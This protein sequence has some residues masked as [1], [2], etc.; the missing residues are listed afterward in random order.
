M[1]IH[2]SCHPLDRRFAIDLSTYLRN[3]GFAS[4]LMQSICNNVETKIAKS[5]VVIVILRPEYINSLVYQY[6]SEK[7][8]NIRLFPI[9]RSPIDI[10]DWNRNIVLSPVVDFTNHNKEQVTS[11]LRKMGDLL[12]SYSVATSVTKLNLQEIYLD[13]LEATL[14]RQYFTVDL[15]ETTNYGCDSMSENPVHTFLSETLFKVFSKNKEG[16]DSAGYPSYTMDTLEHI[17]KHHKSY[18]VICDH[19]DSRLITSFIVDIVRLQFIASSGKTP[20][21]ILL[22]IENWDKEIPWAKWLDSQINFS[23]TPIE[24]LETRKIAL[25]ISE[26]EHSPL[27]I[28]QFSESFKEWWPRNSPPPSL[29][30]VCA[31]LDNLTDYDTVIRPVEPNLDQ[32]KQIC[33]KYQNRPFAQFLLSCSEN[34]KRFPE[35]N[36]LVRNPVFLSSLLSMR[37]EKEIEVS[38]QRISDYF[39]HFLGNLW[40]M[41]NDKN[42]L[43]ADFSEITDAL[44]KIAAIIT[45]RHK[46]FI[47]YDEALDFIQSET[48]LN[49]CID[50]GLFLLTDN[51]LYF[52]MLF[53]QDYFAAVAL[54]QYGIPSHLPRLVLTNQ[55][56]RVSQRWDNPIIISSHIM[57]STEE[58]LKTITDIDPMLALGCITS[59]VSLNT[60]LYTYIIDKNLEALVNVGDFRTDFAKLLYAIDPATAKA[61]LVEVLRNARWS[62]RLYA[63]AAFQDLD[64]SLM[65]GLAESLVDVNDNTRTRVSQAIRRIGSNALPTLF[66]LLHDD[67][68]QI[69]LGAIWAIS[70]LRDKAFVP[71]LIKIL[72]DHNITVSTQAAITLGALGD[73]DS[74]TYLVKH[75]HHRH[76]SIR[77]AVINALIEIQNKYSRPFVDIIQQLDTATRRLVVVY[78]SA[79]HTNTPLDFLLAFSHDE[80]VD[81]RIVAI[82]GLATIAEPRVISRLEECLEDMSKSRLRKS[83]VSEIVSRILSNIPGHEEATSIITKDRDGINPDSTNLLNSSQI[84]KVRLLN[85]KEQRANT[86]IANSDNSLHTQQQVVDGDLSQEKI[87]VVSSEDAYVSDILAQLRGRNWNT[88]SNAAK[89][90]RNYVKTLRGNT[91][92]KVVNQILETL[93]DNDW[94]IRWVG[95][96]T[97]GWV[98]NM[99][100]VPHLIQRLADSNWK[101]RIAAIRALAEIKDDA[102]IV[103]LSTLVSDD[104]AV[105]REAAAEALGFIDGK[106]AI[107]ALEAAALDPE[108]F[109][110][111]AAVESLGKT[112]DKIATR[113]LLSALKDS[114]EHVRWA[115]VNSLTGIADANMVSVLIPS[116]LDTAG[117]YWEQKRICDVIVD[118]LKQIGTE[119]ARNALLE[120]QTSQA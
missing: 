7:L 111:L 14:K 1:S 26:L 116:L 50:T 65:I 72:W 63:Y 27:K 115:A 112:H 60:N 49:K 89:T 76:A 4:R 48:L 24:D 56:N 100:V 53:I 101:V 19:L 92:L 73:L 120:W 57:L 80:N 40:N 69:R 86:E 2:I 85:A 105:V 33:V 109:V 21:P 25:Y 39:Q 12:I 78:L 88:S 43:E 91:S 108:D 10:D 83:T 68:T 35:I 13:A 5:D 74:V 70:E 66:K 29:V 23:N 44:S 17:A 107:H 59:G 119:E 30:M 103:G 118:I 93:N 32:L 38:Q 31:N 67:N 113:A 79:S 98:G 61:I 55:S 9:L 8:P 95:V 3:L 102:A 36:Y 47:I 106:Q 75:L 96:E 52:S 90:L 97:L 58:M 37:F 84:V 104:N 87:L 28:H 41:G 22:N 51:K 15:L 16:S 81:V 20:I 62:I 34:D 77:K 18:T 54:V 64:S 114:S 110:R 45:D 82:E 71:A 46:S 117:P 94:V 6:L 42:V 99:H 11:N